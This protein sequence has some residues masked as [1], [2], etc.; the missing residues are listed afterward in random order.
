MEPSWRVSEIVVGLGGRVCAVTKAE[1][2]TLP[3]TALATL[4]CRANEARRP[5]GIIDDPMAIR[6]LQ[7]S[8]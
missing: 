6:G 2:I 3:E 5:E 1:V 8:F 4:L 7:T